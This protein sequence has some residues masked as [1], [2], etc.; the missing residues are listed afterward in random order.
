MADEIMTPEECARLRTSLILE[1]QNG[2]DDYIDGR[3]W[4]EEFSDWLS[5]STP[6]V[7]SVIA[8]ICCKGEDPGCDC[9]EI[10]QYVK[11]QDAVIA[12]LEAY[13]AAGNFTTFPATT[14]LATSGPLGIRP[15]ASCCVLKIVEQMEAWT[16][17][18]DGSPYPTLT[19]A[20]GVYLFMKSIGHVFIDLGAK[21]VKASPL[22]TWAMKKMTGTDIT[23]INQARAEI[24]LGRSRA[25]R[26]L[27]KQMYALCCCRDG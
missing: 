4:S 27:L 11:D 15:N 6:T 14:A 23:D 13:I 10:K 1:I 24:E 17:W 22:E 12:K 26:E 5:N 20:H 25:F 2:I 8:R 19:F 9:E 16:A 7:E 3:S 18:R 21:L